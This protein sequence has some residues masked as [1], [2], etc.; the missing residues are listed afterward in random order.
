MKKNSE[1]TSNK[2]R[3]FVIN[4]FGGPGTGKS[5]TAMGLTSLLKRLGVSCEYVSEYVKGHVWDNNQ[6]ALS[7]QPTIFG[8]QLD[9]LHKLDGKVD[10]IITDSPLP[11]N[12]LHD[13]F[14]V[15]EHYKAWIVEVFNMF[16]NINILL[17]VDR[18][19]IPY[20]QQGRYESA[21]RAK[22]MD[23]ENN[24]MLIDN[25]I[26]FVVFSVGDHTIEN[27]SNYIRAS[28]TSDGK[29]LRTAKQERE[30]VAKI[31]KLK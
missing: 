22:E 20:E 28:Y 16:D 13:G 30:L 15:T 26:P 10:F 24:Q 8:D 29:T 1:N 25:N 14:G 17:T 19:K 5:V 31:A 3:T 27:I 12:L 11:I 21:K 4:C 2:K 7:C 6:R 23:K 9:E 18:K